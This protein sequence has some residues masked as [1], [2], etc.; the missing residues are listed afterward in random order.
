MKFYELGSLTCSDS[1]LLLERRS[2][3]LALL[4][5]GMSTYCKTYTYTQHSTENV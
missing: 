5:H 1:E 2:Y 3:H 4:L